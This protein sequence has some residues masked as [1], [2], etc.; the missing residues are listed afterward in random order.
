MH[1]PLLMEQHQ[2]SQA[3]YLSVHLL[4]Q[5]HLWMMA[6]RKARTLSKLLIS[7]LSKAAVRK[8]FAMVNI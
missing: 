8:I 4:A 1:Q 3:L 2:P 6:P 7:L 5:N